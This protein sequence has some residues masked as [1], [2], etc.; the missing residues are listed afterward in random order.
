MA[1]FIAFPL[2]FREAFLGRTN[3][4]E[5]VLLLIR[6]MASTPHGSWAGCPHFGWR[7]FFEHARTRPE[8]PQAAMEEANLALKDLG[9]TNYRVAAITRE[10]SANRDVDSYVVSIASTGSDAE[11]LTLRI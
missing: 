11:T 7:D 6:I 4:V 8:L 1:S 10:S 5:A 9:V 3:E 2:R